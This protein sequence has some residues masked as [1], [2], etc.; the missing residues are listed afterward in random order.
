[1]KNYLK[2]Y[3]KSLARHRI[4]SSLGI[5]AIGWGI[6]IANFTYVPYQSLHFN[7]CYVWSNPIALMIA[8]L[9]L[10]HCK[11]HDR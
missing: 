8:G 9:A 5:A 4:T 6:W 10:L 3:L 7:L 11:D 1:M 2:N